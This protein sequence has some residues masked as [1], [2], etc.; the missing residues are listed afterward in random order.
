M[1]TTPLVV[2]ADCSVETVAKQAMNRDSEKIYDDI[3]VI[4]QAGVLLGIVSVQKMLDTLAQV[5]VELAKGSNPL[6]GLPGNVSIEME[7]SLRAKN[8]TPSSLIYVDLDNFK[9][10]NDVYGFANGD[11]VILLT[12]KVL[13]EAVNDCDPTAFL[14]HVGGDDFMVI[15]APEAADCIGE[16]VVKAFEREAPAMYNEQDRDAGFVLAKGRDGVMAKFPFVS[17]SVG[18]V[19]CLFTYPFSSEE[20]SRRTAEVKKFAKSRPGNSYVRDRRSALGAHPDAS[21]PCEDKG[22]SPKLSLLRG[23]AT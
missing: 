11:R 6:T 23:G 10:Y 17:L 3:I 15:S 8:Q 2:D 12:S 7:I 20:L 9:V 21:Q 18:V 13:R 5:H 22:D 19:D 4:D 14:G 1:D 16:R